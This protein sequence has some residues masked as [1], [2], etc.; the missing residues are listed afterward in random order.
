M[1]TGPQ[2]GLGDFGV[3]EVLV[4]V[5]NTK[6]LLGSNT[7]QAFFVQPSTSPLALQLQLLQPSNHVWQPAGHTALVTVVRRTVVVTL[8]V[9]EEE[10]DEE[11]EDEDDDDDE[12]DA[13]EV[14][15]GVVDEVEDA[16]VAGHTLSGVNP[17]Q[18]PSGVRKQRE[19]QP[20]SV[21]PS[22]QS[23]L[24]HRSAGQSRPATSQRPVVD[25]SV[26]GAEV[27]VTHSH[28]G[29]PSAL[30]TKPSG[31]F[32]RH[33]GPLHTGHG[34]LHTGLLKDSQAISVHVMAPSRVHEHVLH[35]SK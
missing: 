15:A 14:G 17:L 24:G 21:T 3:G 7:V 29:Q 18:V 11:E 6:Q 20:Y 22:S 23:R 13:V 4:E 25:E 19:V 30:M 27:V 16:V 28:V 35:P 10:D 26:A 1:Q 31:H 9:L 34:S 8:A 33:S 5:A 12:E 32:M 2:V